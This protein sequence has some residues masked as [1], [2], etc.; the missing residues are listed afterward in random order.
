MSDSFGI[1][2]IK[3]LTR[4][5]VIL[6][7]G[8]DDSFFFGH[9]LEN[10]GANKESIGIISITGHSQL[11]ENLVSLKK[12]S[13]FVQGKVTRIAV[14]LDAD[15]DSASALDRIHT[16]YRACDFP[17]PAHSHFTANSSGI[18][19]GA[20]VIPSH[21]GTDDL[22]RLCLDTIPNNPL[23]GSARTFLT[24][25]ENDFGVPTAKRYK[26][27]AQIFLAL[28][29]IETRGVGRSFIDVFDINHESLNGIRDFVGRLAS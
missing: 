4:P 27:L 26:R 22:E 14:A 29:N 24:K 28:Q 11:S 17:T 15:T 5:K 7:E 10:L 20:Y 3:Q 21:P 1:P 25:M 18:E 13:L 8:Q 9:L 23:L 2:G 6:V 16:A 19:F 12:S